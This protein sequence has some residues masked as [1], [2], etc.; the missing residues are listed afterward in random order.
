MLFKCETIKTIDSMWISGSFVCASIKNGG[1][2]CWDF[3]KDSSNMLSLQKTGMSHRSVFSKVA[4]VGNSACILS[5]GGDSVKK[6]QGD[7]VYV[8]NNIRPYYS[9]VDTIYNKKFTLQFITNE[10]YKYDLVFLLTHGINDKYGTFFLTGETADISSILKCYYGEWK[11][12]LVRINLPII[13]NSQ[14]EYF[15]GADW[16]LMVSNRYIAEKCDKQFN[17]RLWYAATCNQLTMP[18]Q[19]GKALIDR[20]VKEVIGWNCEVISTDADV[21][22]DYLIG[23]MLETCQTLGEVYNS[24]PNDSKYLITWG[25]LKCNL[26]ACY[27]PTMQPMGMLRAYPDTHISTS[28]FKLRNDCPTPP[29][30]PT[31]ISPSNGATGQPLSPTLTWSTVTGAATY[32]VQVS[33]S[34]TFTTVVIEDSTLTSAMKVLSVLIN[35]TQYFWRVQAKNEG[36]VSAWS[37]S[38]SFTTITAT[39]KQDSVTDIDGNVYHTVR[40]GTQVWTVENLRTTKYIDG[41][42]IPFVIDN[43][44]WLTHSSPG[45]CYYNNTTNTDSIKLFGALYNWY[46]VNTKKLAP[47]GWHVPMDAEWDTLQNYLIVNGYNWDGTKTGN[48]IAKSLAARANWWSNS[49]AGAIGNDLTKNNSSGFSALP[50]GYRYVVGNFNYIGYFGSWWSATGTGADIAYCSS[51]A[52]NNDSLIRTNDFEGCGFSVRLVRDN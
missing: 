7:L 46:A 30:M 49:S 11:N 40:I 23:T 33:T 29:Q 34:N 48:K 2:I 37:S 3:T 42:A 39:V 27:T 19:M 4:Q 52:N 51:L 47:S 17:A 50:A 41:S 21:A 38:W 44:I 32:H 8:Y 26:T 28:T 31:L 14:L 43:S 13:G 10:L 22:G 6:S 36:G 16:L 9:V 45:Y 5:G 15:S 20:G 35:G 1:M 18:E 25:N 24:I 12:N